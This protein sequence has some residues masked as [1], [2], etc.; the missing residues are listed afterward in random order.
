MND[1]IEK[2]GGELVLH[3]MVGHGHERLSLPHSLTL[4]HW[5]MSGADGLSVHQFC[6]LAGQTEQP[7]GL[8]DSQLRRLAL[9]FLLGQEL[10][11]KRLV[12]LVRS[13][14]RSADSE[15]SEWAE[16]CFESFTQCWPRRFSLGLPGDAEVRSA[17]RAAFVTR[18]FRGLG[19]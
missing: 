6:L 14:G 10:D 15:P 7:V 13:I 4:Q 5:L 11:H 8:L 2:N 12:G 1:F 18:Y 16:F 19:K 9:L 17:A 3:V